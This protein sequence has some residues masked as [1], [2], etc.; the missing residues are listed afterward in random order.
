M[1][2][3]SN[4]LRA[5]ACAIYRASIISLVLV[6]FSNDH[7]LKAGELVIW[8][9]Q[10]AGKWDT[11]YPVGNGRLGAMPQGMFPQEKIL[12]NEETI[13]A[14][15]AGY[16]MPENSLEHLEEVR[17]LEAAGDF[18]GA[19]RHFEKHLENGR[20]PCTYQLVGWLHLDYQ[21]SAPVKQV[22]RELDLKTGVADLTS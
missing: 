5:L 20:S 14:R 6:S 12:I 4:H 7:H 8:D 13:W 1:N 2:I 18:S 16:G 22:H 21:D 3:N 19:D 15:S 9:N 11:A 10:P 17:K